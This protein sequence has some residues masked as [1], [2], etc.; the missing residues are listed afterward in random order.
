[1][2][3]YAR[4]EGSPVRFNDREAWLYINGKWQEWDHADAFTKAGLLTQEAYESMYPDLPPLPEIAF[5]DAGKRSA[6]RA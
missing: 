6:A 3:K 5:Q 1:M 2:I 4:W